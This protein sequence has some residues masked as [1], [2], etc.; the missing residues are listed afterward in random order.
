MPIWA[1]IIALI[2]PHLGPTARDLLALSSWQFHRSR[3]AEIRASTV[4]LQPV[5][6]WDLSKSNDARILGQPHSILVSQFGGSDDWFWK[7]NCHVV[8]RFPGGR[9][10]D[11]PASDLHARVE[12]G[13]VRGIG[14]LTSP[15]RMCADDLRAVMVANI[16]RL[17]VRRGADDSDAIR[18]V[19]RYIA[20]T[21]T[22]QY[23]GG[24]NL[25]S[26]GGQADVDIRMSGN[27]DDWGF[28]LSYDIF[29]F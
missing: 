21:I 26:R 29:W 19:D 28:T 13:R 1:C 17:H 10:I 6:Y 15:R 3:V 25:G 18:C 7:V 11:S 5:I 24:E 4:P 2:F 12:N 20:K 16:Q 14:F 9:L 22:G 23:V 27:D 8:I